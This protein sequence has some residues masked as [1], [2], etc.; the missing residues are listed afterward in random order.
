MSAVNRVKLC[1]RCSQPA[2]LLYRVKFE[3]NGKWVFVC[4]QCWTGVSEN[5][6]F[7]VYG[8]TWKARKQRK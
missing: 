7:Y 8:G 4:P 5:N 3:E 6:P 2:P 1:Y